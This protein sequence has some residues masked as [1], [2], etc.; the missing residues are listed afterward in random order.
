MTRK[1]LHLLTYFRALFDAI[2][3]PFM[4]RK[5]K[6]ASAQAGRDRS[7]DGHRLF[8]CFHCRIYQRKWTGVEKRS[9]PY[10]YSK[11]LADIRHCI[12][13]AGLEIACKWGWWG[14][15]SF[16]KKPLISFTFTSHKPQ[17]Q[18]SSSPIPRIRI[19]CIPRIGV[20][21]S[22]LGRDCV[23]FPY[24]GRGHTLTII[25]TEGEGRESRESEGHEYVVIGMWKGKRNRKKAP[26]K[27]KRKNMNFMRL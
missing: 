24:S 14:W 17:L 25:T 2:R 10:I 22:I 5:V 20:F 4:Q 16:L 11:S 7:T 9:G 1:Y 15:I 18:V 12:L 19:W 27:L 3:S 21:R 23:V 8:V 26:A 13:G 6:N